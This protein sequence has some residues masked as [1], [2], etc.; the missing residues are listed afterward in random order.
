MTV[1][2]NGADFAESLFKCA[3][4]ADIQCVKLSLKVFSLTFFS[5]FSVL[6]FAEDSVYEIP[7][8]LKGIWQ[9]DGRY[10]V[11]DSG[12]NTAE[13]AIPMIVLRTFYRW[14]DDRAAEGEVATNAFPRDKNNTT[15][16]RPEKLSIQFEPLTDQVFVQGK[17]E[18]SIQDDGDSITAENASS[19]A[20]DMIIHY[21]GKMGGKEKTCHVPIAVIGD[22]L[23]L[24][25]VVKQEDSDS[26]PMSSLLNGK[27]IESGNILAGY[28]RNYEK[29]QGILIST[30]EQKG[31][32]E[33]LCYFVTDTKVY[34]L[35]YWETDMEFDAE[36]TA[37]FD[38]DGK[39]IEIPKHLKS[40]EK[41][42]TCVK[43]RRTAVR[44]LTEADDFLQEKSTNTIL[45][46]KV[47]QNDS[48]ETIDYSVRTSTICAFGKPY[49]TRANDLSSIQETI[50]SDNSRKKPAPEPLFPPHG[51]LD[52]DWSIIS[53][54]PESY[55]RRMLDL[56]K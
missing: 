13:S 52:F 46:H 16:Q 9:N 14:Y 53:D 21:D 8:L 32:S 48:G 51:I 47:R 15:S 1:A 37:H 43:G 41:I 20:W 10:I 30:Q 11:F 25:F 54:P 39:I 31:Q 18:A 3:K 19:G 4:N 50:E 23:Y 22:S 49:L 27:I 24:D 6:S 17:G 42:F 33:L 44:N 45:V 29:A 26:V 7:E 28:W 36:A 56:G 55:D 34:P 35:R 12:E 40:G 2:E 38:A 5:L